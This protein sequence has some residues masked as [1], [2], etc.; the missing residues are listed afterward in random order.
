[1][2]EKKFVLNKNMWNYIT[3]NYLFQE[4]LLED[5]IVY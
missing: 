4:Y 5:I 2:F 1:M 3:V